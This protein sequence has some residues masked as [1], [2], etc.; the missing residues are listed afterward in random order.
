MS[1]EL[2]YGDGATL[3][4]DV[5]LEAVL[6]DGSIPR[7]TPL[8]D[9]AAAVAVAL[10]HP[11]DF[12]P[13]SQAVIPSDRVVLAL[14]DGLPAVAAIVA[15]V[16][17]TLLDN[18][19]QATNISLLLAPGSEKEF[20]KH[21]TSGLTPALRDNLEVTIHDPRD[22][23]ALSYL[24]ASRAGHP[25]YF[26]RKLCDADVVL[27]ISTLRL[28]DSFGYVGVHGGL[29][30]TFSD[31]TTQ[32]RFR[33]PANADWPAHRRRRE[34]ET[35]EAAW[36]LGIQC[37]VQVAPGPGDSVLHVLA[38][39]APSIAE[40][41]RILCEAAWRHRAP[42]RA[43]LVVATIEGG[44]DQQT[45]ENFARA[46]FT[47][48]QAVVDGGA[49][50]LCTNLC[51]A[52]GPAMKH[53]ADVSRSDEEIDRSL[54]RE[55]SADANSATLLAQ[56]QRR[57]QVYLLSGLDEDLVEDLGLGHVVNAEAVQR[58][59][60]QHGSLILLGNAQHAVFAANEE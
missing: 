12:P 44:P 17:G 6:A 40:K 38:G 21:A 23:A 50:V 49:I 4:L 22:S 15:G 5:P 11:L 32:Q 39:S 35:D 20:R 1:F 9:P 24:A 59:S 46:L 51:R 43:S 54:R 8:S 41:G 60:R 31:E 3:R 52:P 16:V 19:A 13:L 26:H 28:K 18:G 42:R 10:A 56:I 27:P 25:I 30:P 29:F 53:L 57:A 45:W 2:K 58:L 7:G 55:R 37:I 47:A 14:E 33:A 36:L 48:S 34:E